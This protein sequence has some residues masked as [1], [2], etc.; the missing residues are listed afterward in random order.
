[1]IAILL[2]LQTG[3]TKYCCFLCYWK[4][5]ARDKH[6][7]VKVWSECNSFEPGQRN[8][9]EDPLVDNKNVILPPLHI[10]V[11]IVKNFLTAIVRNGNAFG[12]LKSKFLK[13]SDAKIREGV[14]IGLQT[15]ELMQD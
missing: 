4:S 5:K 9:V 10:N 6:H 14:F 11:G 15:C 1:M 13:L 12:Y 8:V 3:Y 2:E 7:T